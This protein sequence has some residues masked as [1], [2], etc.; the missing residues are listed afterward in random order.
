M[1]KIRL[2]DQL[3]HRQERITFLYPPYFIYGNLSSAILF[4]LLLYFFLIDISINLLSLLNL[5][6]PYF[7]LLHYKL[8]RI[9]F[10]V[11]FFNLLFPLYISS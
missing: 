3:L 5:Y 10:T 1:L 2:C 9:T 8:K 7:L 4:L 11:N 6:L